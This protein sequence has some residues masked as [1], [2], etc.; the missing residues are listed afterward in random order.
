MKI[1][2]SALSLA[3]LFFLAACGG[4]GGTASNSITPTVT[5]DVTLKIPQGATDF[6]QPITVKTGTRVTWDNTDAVPHTVTSASG[7]WDSGRLNAV[8][9][10]FSYVFA[11]PGTYNYNSTLDGQTSMTGTVIV[12][13]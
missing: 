5:G 7:L 10:A 9:G 13:Q 11:N 8:E 2:I 4:S 3:G 6:G 1:F 12:T